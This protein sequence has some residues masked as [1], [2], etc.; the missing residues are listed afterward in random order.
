MKHHKILNACNQGQRVQGICAK[1]KLWLPVVKRLP[2]T[3]CNESAK[4]YNN[5]EETDETGH[6]EQY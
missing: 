4:D 1:R 5:Q 6:Y 2:W 3:G